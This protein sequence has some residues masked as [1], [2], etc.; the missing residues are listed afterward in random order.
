MH[1][2][3]ANVVRMTFK[4]VHTFQRVV[5]EHT[6]LEVQRSCEKSEIHEQS[7]GFYSQNAFQ[8]TYSF[9]LGHDT[10]STAKFASN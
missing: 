10:S 3:G 5:V 1:D 2:D 8:L 7:L 9:K 4:C 6:D